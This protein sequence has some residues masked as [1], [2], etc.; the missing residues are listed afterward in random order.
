MR[1]EFP[2]DI[3]SHIN[4]ERHAAS[5][6]SLLHVVE[7]VREPLAR[8]E[9]RAIVSDQPAIGEYLASAIAPCNETVNDRIACPRPNVMK[10]ATA[11]V[12]VSASV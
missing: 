7:P 2:Q 5:V 4:A 9:A 3:H 8:D 12:K 1:H 6:D 10:S 11:M